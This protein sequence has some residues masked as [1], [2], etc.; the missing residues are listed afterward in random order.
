[1]HYINPYLLLNIASENL[2]DININTIRKEKGKLLAEIEL[3]DTNTIK[4]YG[5]ELSKGDCIR[6]IDELDIHYKKEFHHFICMQKYLNQFLTNGD[7][8]FFSNYQT[9]SIYKF[10]E[11]IDFIGDYFAEQY[12]KVLYAYYQRNDTEAVS[13][14]ISIDPITNVK[15]YDK[16][17]KS[18]YSDIRAIIDDVNKFKKNIKTNYHIIDFDD[19]SWVCSLNL[20]EQKIQILNLLPSYFLSIRNKFALAIKNFASVINNEPYSNFCKAFQL[21]TIAKSIKTEADPE[22][23]I[24]EAYQIIKNNYENDLKKVQPL[25]QTPVGDQIINF[26]WRHVSNQINEI[27]EEIRNGSSKFISSNF[28]SLDSCVKQLVDVSK[29]NALSTNFQSFKNLIALDICTLA[30]TVNNEPYHNY[31]IAFELISL[32]KSIMIDEIEAEELGLAYLSIKKNYEKHVKQIVAHEKNEIEKGH[33]KALWEKKLKELKAIH[34]EAENHQITNYQNLDDTIYKLILPN[35][36]NTLSVEFQDIRN[37]VANILCSLS[38]IVSSDPLVDQNIAFQLISIAKGIITSYETTDFITTTFETI[39]NKRNS[40]FESN[41]NNTSENRKTV[42]ETVYEAKLPPNSSKNNKKYIVSAK[43]KM[44]RI[45]RLLNKYLQKNSNAYQWFIVAFVLMMVTVFFVLSLNNSKEGSSIVENS[46]RINQKAKK[47]P[48]IFIPNS[49]GNKFENHKTINNQQNDVVY[50]YPIMPNGEIMGCSSIRF[51]YDRKVNNKLIISCGS[52]AN[53]VVKMIDNLTYK[54]IRYVFI[55]KS[56]SFT[57][58]NIPEGKY[59]LKIAYGNDWGLRLGETNCNGR[60]TK[61]TFYKKGEEILDYNFIHESDGSYQ[62]PS[63]SLTLDVSYRTE[64]NM[65]DFG[66]NKISESDFF[67]E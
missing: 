26:I 4:Y 60:F 17:Y 32:A 49:Q 39:E 48:T 5:I 50:T 10:P 36:L 22:K 51:R 56:T 15:N 3:S 23:V 43:S 7:L 37:Q 54:T 21:I 41:K 47:T 30:K 44:Y 18:T 55:N 66:T 67:N 29:L 6:V 65:K 46:S 8:I 61:N 1:M 14:I 12:D 19:N 27:S 34:S 58:W 45:A 63:F 40:Q 11:F 20:T 53:V 38:I 31:E 59:Y 25:K 42:K 33:Q 57:I 28:F 2:N 16:C 9:E 62:V 13:K 52:N 24:Q 64:D 35:T